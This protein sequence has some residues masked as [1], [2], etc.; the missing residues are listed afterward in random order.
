VVKAITVKGLSEYT[1]NINFYGRLKLCLQ[2]D[3]SVMTNRSRRFKCPDVTVTANR[4]EGLNPC[5][6]FLWGF[7][8]E[9][10]FSKKPQKVR[11][12]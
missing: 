8:K 6:Y 2:P 1:K 9:K 12:F 4:A 11:T 5:D 7:L 10:V 3:V